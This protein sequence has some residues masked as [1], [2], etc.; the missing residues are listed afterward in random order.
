MSTATPIAPQERI[1]LLDIIRGFALLGILLMN[2]EYFQRPLGEMMH[3]FNTEQAGLDYATAW[4]VYTFVQGKFYTMFSLLFGMGF[5]LFLDRAIEKTNSPRF[6]FFR[7][8]FVLALFGLV[9]I[10]YIWGGDILLN[11]AIVGVFLLLFVKTSAGRLWK[12]GAALIIIPVLLYWLGAWGMQMGLNS[13]AGPEM[14]AQIEQGGMEMQKMIAA[15]HE[16]YA[17]GGYGE[18]VGYRLTEI[19]LL[20]GGGGIVFFVPTI[21]GTI[22]IGAAFA[23]AG[24]F[25]KPQAHKKALKNM[26]VFGAIFGLPSALA[27]GIYGLEMNL[28]VPDYHGALIFTLQAVANIGLCFAYMGILALLFLGG[29]KW[30]RH[31]APAG[32]MA[33]TNYLTHSIVFT[34]LFYG[35]GFGLYGEYGRFATTVMAIL[36]YVGQL[37]FSTWWLQ[38]YQYGPMEWL[39]RSA[40]YMKLQPMRK[41]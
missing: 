27:V 1:H 10:V 18:V 20:Y 7:R 33:L 34:T 3:G 31:L 26:L 29:K 35:Y 22:L 25:T 39:W 19:A 38:R 9:H 30:L 8:I 6:L 14:L 32:R 4:S 41:A 23:R 37:W 2:I 40:T 15:G 5:V 11:Y 21:L 16:I 17:Q 12:W 36:L 13:P 24:I 28:M